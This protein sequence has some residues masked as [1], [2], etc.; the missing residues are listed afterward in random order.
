MLHGENRLAH[1]WPKFL[2]G[3]DYNEEEMSWHLE[4][5]LGYW[6]VQ[7]NGNKFATGQIL[8]KPVGVVKGRILAGRAQ[9]FPE[10][11]HPWFHVKVLNPHRWSSSPPS[12]SSSPS[13]SA[14]SD[15]TDCSNRCRLLL[16]RRDKFA[17]TY[18]F[19]GGRAWGGGGGGGGG[20]SGEEEGSWRLCDVKQRRP[21]EG[22]KGISND[23]L[24]D[25]VVGEAEM[26]GVFLE[27]WSFYTTS[28]CLHF[29]PRDDDK[30]E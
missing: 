9:K 3:C 28:V 26:C 29:V 5:K 27:S 18:S 17:M 16:L 24:R 12:S 19:P 25:T 4:K 2:A 21:S 7:I 13:P 14:C 22:A 6:L 8:E 11:W 30:Y 23:V 10:P 1:Q 20:G 15:E